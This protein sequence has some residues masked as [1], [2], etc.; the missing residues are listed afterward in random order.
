[1]HHGGPPEHN[2]IYY[3]PEQLKGGKAEGIS[4][5]QKK[6]KK[7]PSAEKKKKK[8]MPIKKMVLIPDG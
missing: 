4:T 5:G 6:A 3:T 1:M 2:D 7:S 8:K